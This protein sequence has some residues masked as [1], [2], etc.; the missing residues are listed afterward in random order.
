MKNT[1]VLT[2]MI[3]LFFSKNIASQT[4]EKSK[5]EQAYTSYFNT[6]R[7]TIHLHIN[8]NIFI[9]NEPIWFKGYVYDKKNG[10]PFINTTNVYI[11]LLDSN[12]KE[13]TNKLF[14]AQNGYF[15]GSLD[16]NNLIAGDTY[17]IVAYTNWMNNFKED[18]A[19][20]S[21]P[22][23]IL[24][25]NSDLNTSTTKDSTTEKLKHDLQFLPEGG[26]SIIG[27]TNTFG[28]KITDCNARGLE[29]D[30]SIVNSKNEPITNFKSNIFGLGKFDLL[31]EKNEKYTAKY[32]V[33]GIDYSKEIVIDSEEGFA[34]SV[35]NYTNQEL[36]YITL[37]TNDVTLKN[38]TGLT[39]Y[40]VINQNNKVVV[41]DLKVDD[42]KTSN[43]IPV[44]KKNLVSGINTITLFNE[45]SEPLIERL[46]FN[47]DDSLILNSDIIVNT[48]A[49][50]S[51]P[52]SIKTFTH[53]KT[54][55]ASNLSIAILPD[56]TLT[57]TN[58]QN[59][60]SSFLLKPYVKG[61]IQN[62]N[63]Y[64]TDIN[65]LKTYE[66][67]LL[68]LTQGW[69]KYKW[70]NIKTG[71]PKITHNFDAG[72]SI[73]G[74]LNP[75]KSSV[76]YTIQMFS[77]TNQINESTTLVNNSFSFNNFYL[78]DSASINFT[79]LKGDK[80]INNLKPYI[81]ITDN[82]RKLLKQPTLPLINKCKTTTT[83]SFSLEHANSL[84]QEL[85]TINLTYVH[86]K[87][88]DTILQNRK[89]Y[90]A[91]RYSK[92]IKVDDELRRMY[93]YV[94]DIIN[95]HGFVVDQLQGAGVVKIKNRN[96]VT[97]MAS[98]EP[99]LIIDGSSYDRNY[100]ILY[101]MTLEHVDEIFIDPDGNG[102]GSRGGA[103]IIRIYLKQSYK[104]DYT[105]KA[106]A[107][108][109]TVNNGFS[110]EKKFYVPE[111]Y[112]LSKNDFINYSNID[113]KSN[114]ETDQSGNANFKIFNTNIKKA[115][116]VIQGF[117]S[118]GKLLSEIKEINLID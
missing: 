63:Y 2:I 58:N 21:M 10:V 113:W 107:N 30:G 70:E 85:D 81:D 27:V 112:A 65:R 7:E 36:T 92:G 79:V 110:T 71:T 59:L 44:N 102:Y 41:I 33:N 114:I 25:P 74:S 51:I 43:V 103:G 4:N 28:F 67:D 60:I 16:T 100:D 75:P 47:Y 1:L 76:P 95:S 82:N 64:F 32:T 38:N 6:E 78:K 66:L 68:L 84:G 29:I 104:L 101:N 49:N 40:L 91:N 98:N 118:D 37:K 3:A 42:L 86:K 45:K 117:S 80:V 115:I 34:I 88:S 73:K 15:T 24:N 94:T 83:N 54:P 105:K 106:I 8:K 116:F 31:P 97:F 57:Q 96:P 61:Y 55:I 12:G 89:E 5:I 39:Y 48:K 108:E 62:P 109:F 14:F 35:N 77:I 13:I 26:Y 50:D 9:S 72:L 23:H 69:S 99:L 18:E 53:T 87:N 111:F 52:L 11:S 90:I 22:L 93:S 17:Y 46:I 20:V 56:D 19:Y